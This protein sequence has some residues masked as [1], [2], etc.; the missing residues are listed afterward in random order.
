MTNSA[1]ARDDP[2]PT[3]TIAARAQNI[4]ET[5]ADKRIG[6]SPLHGEIE[7]NDGVASV[8]RDDELV[9]LRREIAL[10][11]VDGR[12]GARSGKGFL[13]TRCN[14]GSSSLIAPLMGHKGHGPI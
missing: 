2:R 7:I 10:R 11:H 8:A 14:V 13:N 5:N 12:D 6:I 4:V 3:V 9:M 1:K